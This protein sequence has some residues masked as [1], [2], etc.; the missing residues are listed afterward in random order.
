MTY[1]FFSICS[2]FFPPLQPLLS[3]EIFSEAQQLFWVKRLAKNVFMRTMSLFNISHESGSKLESVEANHFWEIS[4]MNP[5]IDNS[6][7]GDPLADNIRS[8]YNTTYDEYQGLL[9]RASQ[10]LLY[11]SFPRLSG[12]CYHLGTFSPLMEGSFSL[13]ILRGF[14]FMIAD[15]NNAEGCS[16][17]A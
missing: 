10:S 5:L 8:H 11:V 15:H 6:F 13:R 1:R 4:E 16:L 7:K 3:P 9:P 12:S 14:R 2:P 17:R